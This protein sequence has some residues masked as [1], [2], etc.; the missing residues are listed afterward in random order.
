LGDLKPLPSECYQCH[1]DLL[2]IKWHK[3]GKTA[4]HTDAQ[5]HADNPTA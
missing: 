1:V 5:T 4:A 3:G 2:T